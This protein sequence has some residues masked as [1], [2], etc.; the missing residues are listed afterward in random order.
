M[1]EDMLRACVLDFKGSPI[2]NLPLIKFS[3]NSSYQATI[4]IAPY[5]EIYG[6]KCRSL[7]NW[8]GTRE[9]WLINHDLLERTT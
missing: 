9:K 6:R 7:I 8:F 1:L 3:Y 4:R 2:I 5:E